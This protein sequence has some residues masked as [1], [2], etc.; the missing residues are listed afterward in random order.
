MRALVKAEAKEGLVLR[1]EPI[2]QIGPD[3]ILIKVA[4]T[5]I[6]GTDLHI[7]KWDQWA[8]KTIPVPMVVGHEYAGVV[9]EIG[10]HVRT[11][12]V[13]DRVSGE[14]HLIGMKSRMARAGH[15]HLD[16]GNQ[17]CR[18]QRARSLC[19]ISQASC[20]QRHSFAPR[21]RR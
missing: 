9:T 7:W 4:K 5:G 18:R 20:L 14:G 11:V 8:Q 3:D 21:G 10:S 13:G 17:G 15:F 19:R 6:C 16:P 1:D 12:K 2:P